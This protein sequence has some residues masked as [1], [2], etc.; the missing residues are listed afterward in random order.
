M[1]QKRFWAFVSFA[2]LLF[3][4]VISGGCGGGGTSSDENVSSS[5]VSVIG[6][7]TGELAG[8]ILKA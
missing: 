6:I 2:L 4:T 8:A 7:P 1:R 5:Q 3:L